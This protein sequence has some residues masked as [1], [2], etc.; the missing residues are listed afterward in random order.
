MSGRLGSLR[1]SAEA[2]AA[3]AAAQ[4]DSIAELNLA[5][6]QLITRDSDQEQFPTDRGNIEVI[7]AWRFLLDLGG[8]EPL[9]LAA[10]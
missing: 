5:S 6:S 7:A 2:W 9:Q 3:E 4:R 1:S 10:E 8:P